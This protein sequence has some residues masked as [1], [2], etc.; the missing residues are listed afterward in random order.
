[1]NKLI[2]E[3]KEISNNALEVVLDYSRFKKLQ[4]KFRKYY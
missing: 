2:R 3:F 1:M 4:K